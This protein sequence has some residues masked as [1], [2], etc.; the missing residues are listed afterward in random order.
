MPAGE[1]LHP[2]QFLYHATS[3]RNAESIMRSGIIEPS[4]DQVIAGASGVY[5]F[6]DRHDTRWWGMPDETEHVIVA[7]P[8]KRLRIHPDIDNY[9]KTENMRK[10]NQFAK[11]YPHL[12]PYERKQYYKGY[13]FPLTVKS[14]NEAQDVSQYLQKQGWHGHR[15]ALTGSSDVAIYDPNN[16]K[17]LRYIKPRRRR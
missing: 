8:T 3:P 6:T 11:E 4:S 14:V 13:D 12:T 2:G 16:L 17:V 15:D 7:T 1:Y 5:L 10:Q 9:E